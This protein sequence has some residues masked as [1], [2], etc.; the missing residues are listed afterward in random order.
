[1]PPSFSNKNRDAK[2]KPKSKTLAR[3][4]VVYT[5]LVIVGSIFIIRLFYLQVIKHNY[6]QTAA[7]SDQLKQY[8]I[9]SQRGII[10]ANSNGQTVPLV[11]N[12]TLYTLYADPTQIKDPT[13]EANS[14]QKIIGGNASTYLSQMK[15]SGT[16]YVVI[17]R[18]L[19]S[20]QENQINQ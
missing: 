1:M 9:P 5:C 16:E 18:Q 7:Y 11:L 4:R 6:Y 15:T 10:E 12:Q 19:P 2:S 13:S 20:S 8:Q 14:I 3:I 17:A